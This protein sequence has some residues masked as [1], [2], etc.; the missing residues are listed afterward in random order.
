[1]EYVIDN[2][3]WIFSG[4]GISIIIVTYYGVRNFNKWIVEKKRHDQESLKENF[5]E[6]NL[7]IESGSKPNPWEIVDDIDNAPPFQRDEKSK[8][9][10]GNDVRWIVTVGFIEEI[11]K[12][13]I[14]LAM[15]D[16]GFFPW[17]SCDVEIDQYLWLKTIMPDEKILVT[18]KIQDV[19][20]NVISLS[21]PRIYRIE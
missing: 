1:M 17:V 20:L 8:Y 11:C 19:H 18:G 10:I 13:R 3:D 14:R 6:K 21:N 16:R 9:Y 15:L 5:K 4:A 2:I 7:S 12:T